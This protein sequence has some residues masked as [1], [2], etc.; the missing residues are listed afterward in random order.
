MAKARWSSSVAPCGGMV[1]PRVVT[2]LDRGLLAKEQENL[3]ATDAEGTEA[4]VLNQDGEAE[5][6]GVE[7]TGSARGRV[8]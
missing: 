8:T 6:A 5:Q 3:S 2:R 1:P 7:R 4:V